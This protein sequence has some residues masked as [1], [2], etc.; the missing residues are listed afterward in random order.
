M[1]CWEPASFP[2]SFGRQIFPSHQQT[3]RCR[4]SV[5]PS[6]FP[7]SCSV[8]QPAM[9]ILLIFL[10]NDASHYCLLLRAGSRKLMRLMMMKKLFPLLG[11]KGIIVSECVSGHIHTMFLMFSDKHGFVFV[12]WRLCSRPKQEWPVFYSL[13]ELV[14][15]DSSSFCTRVRWFFFSKCHEEQ[16]LFYVRKKM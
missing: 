3:G 11:T 15:L 13:P 10:Q 14:F 4:K 7:S 8:F 16:T 9:V 2:E 5:T 1:F 6:Q 12:A